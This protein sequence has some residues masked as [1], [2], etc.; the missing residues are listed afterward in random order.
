MG[1]GCHH[2]GV[3]QSIQILGE[4]GD[5]I[6]VQVKGPW[7]SSGERKDRNWSRE[8]SKDSVRSVV[9]RFHS[10]QERR[11]L[12]LVLIEVEESRNKVLEVK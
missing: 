7:T 2:K 9:N 3:K 11:Y 4:Q 1:E 10:L 6:K 8:L 5:C 12:G